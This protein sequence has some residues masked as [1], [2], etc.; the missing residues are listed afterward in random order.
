MRL[1]HEFITDEQNVALEGHNIE[2]TPTS[3]G[4]WLKNDEVNNSKVKLQPSI[5]SG[6]KNG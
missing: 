2:N 5:F 4:K 3:M 1:T 6:K